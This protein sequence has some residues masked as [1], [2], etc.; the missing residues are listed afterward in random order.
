MKSVLSSF[1]ACQCS[2]EILSAYYVELHGATANKNNFFGFQIE[3]NV[4]NFHKRI[5]ISCSLKP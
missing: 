3:Q 2:S 1:T 5:Q 4:K